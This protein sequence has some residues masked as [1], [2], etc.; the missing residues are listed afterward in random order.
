MPPMPEA[1]D[2]AGEHMYY[3]IRL[4]PTDCGA[5][6]IYPHKHLLYL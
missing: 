1:L 5:G 3:T 6:I 2:A 4:D